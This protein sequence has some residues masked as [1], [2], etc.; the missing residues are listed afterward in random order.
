MS[1]KKKMGCMIVAVIVILLVVFGGGGMVVYK[2]Y[3]DLEKVI[4]SKI[5]EIPEFNK[6]QL[7]EKIAKELDL[8][9]P[10]EEPYMNKSEVEKT[11]KKEL[12]TLALEVYTTKDLEKRIAAVKEK[13]NNLPSIGDTI[14]IKLKSGKTI[15]GKYNGITEEDGF[16]YANI[17]NKPYKMFDVDPVYY[18]MFNDL[19][20]LDLQSNKVKKIRKEIAEKR[21]AV[22]AVKQR[23]IE[24]K[25]YLANGYMK[26]G[27]KWVAVYDVFMEQ[28]KK[29]KKKF[30]KEYRKKIVDIYEENKLFGIMKIDGVQDSIKN[31]NFKDLDIVNQIKG[32]DKSEEKKEDSKLKE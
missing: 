11:I 5:Q 7:E 26:Q 14:E 20:A 13:Y 31:I 22:I 29:E 21:K 4:N 2:K 9:L 25:I 17:D 32:E 18:W 10:V 23:E 6:K 19:V 27:Q 24:K 15:K 16:E 12:R 1:E 28:Y 30:E 8:E 3:N